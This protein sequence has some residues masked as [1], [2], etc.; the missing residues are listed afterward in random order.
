MI[1]NNVFSVYGSPAIKYLDRPWNKHR[2]LKASTV[3]FNFLSYDE[4][5]PFLSRFRDNF[6]NVE[7]YEF[8]ETN[9][10]SMNQI[11]GLAMVQ[12]ITSLT[13]NEEGNPIFQKNWRPYAIF[14]YQYRFLIFTCQLLISQSF[15][16]VFYITIKT[17]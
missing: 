8:T 10:H 13:I 2:A 1:F 4:L 15:K 12:G 14:R 9:L 16:T 5:V 6:P 17:T 11:N 7:H 3:Q